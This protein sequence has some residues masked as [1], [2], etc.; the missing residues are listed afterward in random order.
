MKLKQEQPDIADLQAEVFN[1]LPSLQ[2]YEREKQAWTASHP[3]ATPEQYTSA[4][5]AI[6]KRCGV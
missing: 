1:F 5:L 6:A 4:M 2:S 3:E